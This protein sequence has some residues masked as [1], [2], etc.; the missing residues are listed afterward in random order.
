MAHHGA[1][2]NI[3]PCGTIAQMLMGQAANNSKIRLPLLHGKRQDTPVQ[4]VPSC[5]RQG[6]RLGKCSAGAGAQ[7]SGTLVSE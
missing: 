7:S 5:L 3:I 6:D 2:E 4:P 1:P